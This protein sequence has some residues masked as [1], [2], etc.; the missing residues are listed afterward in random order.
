MLVFSLAVITAVPVAEVKSEN[1]V[2]D[3][4]ETLGFGYHKFGPSG[5]ALGVA[6]RK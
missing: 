3:T 4:D 6:W 2:L 1:E 5:F